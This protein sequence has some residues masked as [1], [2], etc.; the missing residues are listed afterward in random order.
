M[1]KFKSISTELTI[2]MSAALGVI[3][4]VVSTVYIS[5]E[6]KAT[7]NS[8]QTGLSDALKLQTTRIA[9]FI[10]QHGEVVTTMVASPLFLDWFDAYREREKDVSEDAQFPK[11]LQTF[12]NLAQQD[13]ATKAVFM[14]SAFTGEYF[15]NTNGRYFGDGSYYATKRPWWGEAVKQDKLFITQPEVDYV[16]KTIVSSI[17]KTVYNSQGEL[18]GIAGIDILLETLE[19]EV[20]QQLKFQD[21]GQ[22]F[23]LNRDGRLIMFPAD[24]K[25]I[26]PNSDIAQVDQRLSGAQNFANLKTAIQMQDNGFVEVTWQGRPYLAAFHRISLQSPYVDWVAGILVSE[27]VIT[28]PINEAIWKA[29]L[30]TLLILGTASLVIWLVSLKIVKPLKQVVSAMYDVANG[31]RDL[32]KRIHVHAQN[33]VSEFTRQFNKFVEGLH[34]L[35][36]AN[37]EVI[38]KLTESSQHMSELTREGAESADQQ[39]DSINQVATAAEELSYSV[40]SV[41]ENTLAAS[42]AADDANAQS[43]KGLEVVNDASHSISTLERTVSEASTVINKL[44]DDSSKIGEV[45]GVIRSIAEQTNLLALNAAIEAARAGEQGRGFAVVADEVRSLATRTQESTTS[46]Q[47]IIEDLQQSA[48]QAVEVMKT[49]THH[50]EQGVSKTSEAQGALQQITTSLTD[51]KLQSTEIDNQTRQQAKAAEDITKSAASIH[52]L[53]GDTSE[54]MAQVLKSVQQEKALVTELNKIVGTFI[55]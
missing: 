18:V 3:L 13:N 32:T 8:V 27:E 49:G 34:E 21:Q 25:I 35:I 22:P 38:Q 43:N 31:D 39:R 50:A 52:Q 24:K 14:A 29:V 33:E 19:N 55:V 48:N 20:G 41:A 4:L 54:K 53:S 36:F 44:N 23:L 17:K 16:D 28:D 45:L 42:G 6:S 9:T 11:I 40:K 47:A 15:D 7:R 2:Y 26:E 30:T 37:K 10:Q 46:I 51:I 5:H 12:K 1:L